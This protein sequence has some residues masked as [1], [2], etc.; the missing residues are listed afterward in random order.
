MDPAVIKAWLE[1]AY[2]VL[3]LVVL[4]VAIV[5]IIMLIHYITKNS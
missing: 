2:G 4:L 5:A 3:G 1:I